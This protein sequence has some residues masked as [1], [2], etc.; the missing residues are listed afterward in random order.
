MRDVFNYENINSFLKYGKEVN[1][2]VSTIMTYAFFGTIPSLYGLVLKEQYFIWGIASL[3]ITI[4]FTILTF[5]IMLKKNQKE[6][7][8]GLLCVEGVVHSIVMNIILLQ[9]INSNIII[10][11]VIS[12]IPLITG[13]QW[14]IITLILIKRGLY[15]DAK[16]M[17]IKY[18]RYYSMIGGVFGVFI[19]RFLANGIT[20]HTAI[21]VAI[22]AVEV[23]GM[24][25]SMGC[26]NFLKSHYKIKYNVYFDENEMIYEPF[27]N[28]T[29]NVRKFFVIVSIVFCALFLFFFIIGVLSS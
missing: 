27:K 20:Q 1:V 24:C 26:I 11:L 4:L 28:T 14:W 19:A 13:I 7:C 2:D 22:A 29:N 12:A 16:K 10:C 15:N 17:N 6:L 9:M 3:T 18:A 23:I 8:M 21:L 25:C 5:C